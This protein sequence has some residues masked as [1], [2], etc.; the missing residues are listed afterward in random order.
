MVRMDYVDSGQIA[1]SQLAVFLWKMGEIALCRNGI[2]ANAMPVKRN[3]PLANVQSSSQSL[4]ELMRSRAGQAPVVTALIA[5]NML[6]FVAMLLAGAGLWH[7]AGG[8]PLAW[9]ANFGPATQ[10]GQWWRLGTAMFLHFGALHLAVN[11]WALWDAG[12]LVERLYGRWRFALLYLGS[13]VLGNLV[14]LVVQG[15][16]AVSGGAS[17]AVFSLYGALLLFLWRERKQVERGEFRWLFGG[18]LLFTAL[19]LGLGYVVPA[20][21]NAAHAGGLLGGMLLGGLL[22]RPWTA[23]SP[24]TRRVQQGAGLLLLAVVLGLW[25]KLPAPAYRFG[26][27]L[28]ARAS[29]QQFLQDDQRASQHWDSLLA[30]GQQQGLSFDQLAGKID[31]DVAAVYEKS[32]DQLLAATPGG[33]AP[34]APTLEKLQSYAA[35]RAVAAR[36]LSAGLRSRD[37]QKIRDALKQVTPDAKPAD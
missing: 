14:S 30:H 15:S 33:A 32:F 35:Q 22:A 20:I 9:G 28:K 11:M 37:A 16:Q 17:G 21:N 2:N 3:T 23:A 12:R 7:T 4:L 1:P 25:L 10:D 29:I 36:E 26:E 6:V 13:G 8:L 27:E 34:S 19:M 31:S 24:P 5:L 18:A